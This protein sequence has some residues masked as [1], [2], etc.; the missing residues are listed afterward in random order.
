M[1][2]HCRMKKTICGRWG[3]CFLSPGLGVSRFVLA[4][5]PIS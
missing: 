4:L 5:T 1:D 3:L 2:P